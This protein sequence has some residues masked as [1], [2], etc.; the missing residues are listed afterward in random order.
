MKRFYC[1][2]IV[3]ASFNFSLAQETSQHQTAWFN[4]DH[5]MATEDLRQTFYAKLM[6]SVERSDELNWQ[7]LSLSANGKQQI[8]V[9]RYNPIKDA[10]EI[11]DPDKIYEIAKRHDLS[12]TFSETNV[13][14]QAKSYY[15]DDGK[16][17]TSYFIVDDSF[18]DLGILKRE[19]FKGDKR[20]WRTRRDGTIRFKKIDMYYIIDKNNMLFY[21]TTDRATLRK[22]FPDQA[23]SII[24]YIRKNKLSESRYDDIIMLAKYIKT[25]ETQI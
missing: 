13:T 24:K 17:Y 4:G 8:V 22:S 3:L 11:K 10:I 16:I 12:V 1:T 21:L 20:R 2:C 6:Y 7:N 23:P 14:Y 19:S 5:Y 25:F 18:E 9:A 15:G